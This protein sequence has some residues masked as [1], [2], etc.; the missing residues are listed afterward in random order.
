MSTFDKLLAIAVLLA[1]FIPSPA[2]LLAHYIL[3]FLSLSVLFSLLASDQ[4][5]SFNPNSLLDGILYNYIILGG[6]IFLFS[7]FLPDPEMKSGVLLYAVFP[8]AV[9]MLTF[10]SRWKG[11]MENVFV[12]QIVSYF[13]SLLFV[14][15][16][17]LFFIGKTVDLIVLIYYI[18]GAFIVPY[19][20]NV[21]LVGYL[22]F[23]INNKKILLD[24]SALALAVVFYT[25]IAKNEAWF[26][27][28][29][30]AVFVYFVALF[31][32]SLLV[33]LG[34]FVFTRDPDKTLY[35]TMKNGGAA[36]AASL[37]ILPEA[38]TTIISIK[39]FVDV[40]L[41]II[42]GRIFEK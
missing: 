4:K 13:F 23:K 12:F 41:I 10:S 18:V 15:L 33:A 11:K 32:L 24:L 17:A 38:A 25:V 35:A 22:R 27:K 29:L 1:F 19:L 9:S 39:T 30:D 26:M 21:F 28:N 2:L 7:L 37:A 3:F 5:F 31:A 8:P 42:L 20:L 16:A 14:P 36:A 6:A 40:F 34:V